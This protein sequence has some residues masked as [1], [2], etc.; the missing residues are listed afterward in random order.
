[1]KSSSKLIMNAAPKDYTLKEAEK[2]TGIPAN[3]LR[4]YIHRGKIKAHK[5]G[6]DWFIR[7]EDLP[8][9]RRTE[10]NHREDSDHEPSG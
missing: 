5:R 9:K 3:I 1:M 2:L 8:D 7:A 10:G 6:Y 4:V